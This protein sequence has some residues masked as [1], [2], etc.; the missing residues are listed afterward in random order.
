M[1][2]VHRRSD[3]REL[4]APAPPGG[5]VGRCL[6]WQRSGDRRTGPTPVRRGCACGARRFL[7][8]TD[9]DRRPVRRSDPKPEQSDHRPEVG[10]VLLTSP[11][12]VTGGGERDLRSR[13]VPATRTSGSAAGS[14]EPAAPPHP[15]RGG[16]TAVP[17]SRELDR[18]LEADRPRPDDDGPWRGHHRLLPRVMSRP[19][20]SPGRPGRVRSDPRARSA[21]GM[22]PRTAV[23]RRGRRRSDLLAVVPDHPFLELVEAPSVEEDPRMNRAEL[24]VGQRHAKPQA[25]RAATVS[26]RLADIHVDDLLDRIVAPRIRPGPSLPVGVPRS[27]SGPAATCLRSRRAGRSA[28]S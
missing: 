23:D 27:R 28:V 2:L 1:R 19:S 25:G 13:G 5:G 6:P 3:V 15:H 24:V 16:C 8:R 11:L 9:A 26:H 10:Q 7:T 18:G 17:P 12:L 22:T 4:L 20:R 21:H 14:R